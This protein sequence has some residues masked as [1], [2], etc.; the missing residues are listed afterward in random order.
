MANRLVSLL[1]LPVFTA[2]L[3]PEDYGV[4]AMLMTIGGFLTPVF[5]LGLGTSIGIVYFN[6]RESSERQA[7][8]WSAGVLLVISSI[9]LILIGWILRQPLS[10]IVLANEGYGAHTAVAIATTAITVI[11]MPWQLK[12][13][14]EERATAFVMTSF[15][16]LVA[17]L[18]A[19]LWFVVEMKLGALGALSGS[20][21]GQVVG[22]FI[23]FVTASS[24]PT[25][26]DI[27]RWITPLVK[28]GLPMI[29]GFFFLFLMQQWVRWPLEWYH[30]LHAV[31]IYS[32]GSSLG[33]AV[34]ILTGAF[35][36]AWTPFA[37]SH[38]NRQEEG[39]YILGRITFYFI[40]GFGFV[41][42]L[43]FLF[44]DP[45]VRIFTQPPFYEAS[46]VVGLSAATQFVS[47]IFLMLLPPLYFIQRA[48]NVVATQAVA[49]AIMFCLAELLVPMFGVRGA[50]LTVL[51]G[52]VSLVGA[53]WIAMRFMPVLRI[54]Y[55]YSRIGLVL[56]LL[57]GVA[58]L[59][60]GI[61][62]SNPLFGLAFAGSLTV[63]MALVITFGICS[64]D[65]IIREWRGQVAVRSKEP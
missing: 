61:S 3:V 32:V 9:V 12:L 11:A 15:F 7:I 56:A 43:F 64:V 25:T 47:A 23:M 36:S 48:D 62:F 49:T 51:L 54:Q 26:R 21:I 27:A 59:S 37:L 55:D 24:K 40:A 38:A 28:Q 39:A 53:Q 41:T 57:T 45:L 35:I 8:M 46:Q 58:V 63:V 20:L 14:F 1:L 52:F 5:S 10:R 13:Q 17:T 6:T 60:F 16:G 65:E 22:T 31:G 2:Y 18:G 19:S 30:G 42:S 50:A 33:S 29:P 4:V 34:G 44:A